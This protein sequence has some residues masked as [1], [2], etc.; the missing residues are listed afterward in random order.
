LLGAR[1][2]EGRERLAAGGQEGAQGGGR[3]TVAPR[4]TN[5]PAQ[6]RADARARLPTR[7]D[8][9]SL[10][11]LSGGRYIASPGFTLNASYHASMLRVGP[12][13]RKCGGLCGFDR[14]C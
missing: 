7:S 6:T 14:T 1:C 3:K 12:S 9:Q 11:R 10:T 2:V 4:A 13:T 5:A 8:Y